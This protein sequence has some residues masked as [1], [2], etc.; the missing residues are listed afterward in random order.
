MAAFNP[1]ARP[2]TQEFGLM[3]LGIADGG[4]GG[5]PLNLSQNLSS[6]FGK[7]FRIDP[8]G[9]NSASGKYGIPASNPFVV[10]KTP[11]AL[12][13]IYAYGARNP[14]RFG[15]DSKTGAMY[16]SDIGQNIV[17]EVGLVTAGAN[18]GWNI[19]E[20]SFK[21]AGR[22]GV[23][24]VA[25]RSD[26]KML[27]PTVEYAHGDSLLQGQAAITGVVVYRGTAMHTDR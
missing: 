2:N 18:L 22:S 21:Y 20:G 26:P 10:S 14:Q 24:T 16:F 23:D 13:E 9:R 4:S 7:I 11:N 8:L 3:Y 27:Y 19:W 1:L 25:A 5:D 12:G 15:W 6:G 17:E